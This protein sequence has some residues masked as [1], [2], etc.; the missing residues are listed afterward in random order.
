MW[1]TCR[2]LQEMSQEWTHVEGFWVLLELAR[3][4]R[5]VESLSVFLK[6][7]LTDRMLARVAWSSKIHTCCGQ[8]GFFSSNRNCGWYVCMISGAST[9]ST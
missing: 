5:I 3:Q 9:C 2:S 7:I 1:R 6:P 8:L 4:F